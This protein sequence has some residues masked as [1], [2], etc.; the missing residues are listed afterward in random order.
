MQL[1]AECFQ[2]I[3]KSC[4]IRMVASLIVLI[5]LLMEMRIW[6]NRNM[7]L[8][9]LQQSMKQNHITLFLSKQGESGCWIISVVL[10]HIIQ[11]NYLSEFTHK[12]ALHKF[13]ILTECAIG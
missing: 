6:H 7:A 10:K 1:L 9:I 12:P 5:T 11:L 13:I 2:R 3:E 8:S 4:L